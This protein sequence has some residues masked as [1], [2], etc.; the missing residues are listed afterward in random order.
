MQLL[1][2]STEQGLMA[3]VAV[4]GL[5]SL[6]FSSTCRMSFD[7]IQWDVIVAV[8][9]AKLTLVALGSTIAW[10]S[11]RRGDG[12]GYAW[13]LGGTMA[14]MSTMSDDM[15]T[16]LP[17]F[18][19]FFK[20]NHQA[21]DFA[22]INLVILSGLQ[23]AL[24][25]PVIFFILG[26]GRAQAK[27]QRDE[28]REPHGGARSRRRS[29]LGDVLLE[30]LKGFRR[31]MMMMAVCL[32]ALYN[33]LTS[34]APLPWYIYIPVDVAGQAFRP[35]VLVIG[36]MAL[37]GSIGHLSSL[38]LAV[39][40]TLLVVLKSIILPIVSLYFF[41]L[42]QPR[43]DAGTQH[44]P[45][46]DQEQ[47]T[48]AATATATATAAAAS[49]N[50]VD[51]VFYYNILPVATSSLAI[52]QSYDVDS[53]LLSSLA[54][55]L[56][57]GKIVAFSLL[58]LAAYV[59][60]YGYSIL[61]DCLMTLSNC[62]H[63]LSILGG[64]TMLALACRDPKKRVRERHSLL[65]LAVLQTGYSASFVISRY[66]LATNFFELVSS[67]LD[68]GAA[69]V[70][71]KVYLQIKIFVGIFS[72]VSI[73]RWACHGWI[74]VM[75]FDQYLRTFQVRRRARR[76]RLGGALPPLAGQHAATRRRNGGGVGS[77]DDDGGDSDGAAAAGGGGGERS[78]Y[79]VDEYFLSDSSEAALGGTPLWA[80]ALV[81][82]CF[83]LGMTLPFSLLPSPLEQFKAMLARH[84]CLDLKPLDAALWAP[85]ASQSRQDEIYIIAYSASA[86]L[87]ALF[88]AGILRDARESPDDTDD[89]SSAATTNSDSDS[90]VERYLGPSSSTAPPAAS[91]KKRMTTGCWGTNARVGAVAA[92]AAEAVPTPPVS[93][94]EVEEGEQAPVTT[95]AGPT[96]AGSSAAAC[97]AAARAGHA[98]NARLRGRAAAAAI[99]VRGAP[100]RRHHGTA[101]A[102]AQPRLCDHRLSDDDSLRD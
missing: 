81:A 60:T 31:N 58:F 53:D 68:I 32:G 29:S 28:G 34:R 45:Q 71:Y 26:I 75:I 3:F 6:L 87:L 95:L 77:G 36:G 27:E 80:H 92:T 42:L 88:L 66:I 89:G 46:Q 90:D 51:F 67:F 72:C 13:T 55:A 74:L 52:A 84:R 47:P 12:T 63:S 14:L 61:I 65:V 64:V 24:V 83:G 8:I 40:P 73:L 62:T 33:V 93:P 2:K 98:C 56:L 102:A 21:L 10:L 1:S 57:L 41:M 101:P 76:T 39:L 37:S 70:P 44:A 97:A 96:W 43:A 16:G 99:R 79:S 17:I 30:V 11:T 78:T 15:G 7:N 94:H 9:L 50:D 22:V 91:L 82:I 86:L 69:N 19:A 25:N 85:Y 18:L 4:I 5:P 54:S 59:I 48:G 49:A 38:R 23:S 35:L 20:E 100:P